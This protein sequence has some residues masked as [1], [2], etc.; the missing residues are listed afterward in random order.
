MLKLLGVIFCILMGMGFKSTCVLSHSVVSYSL[1]PHGLQPSRL[2]CPWDCPGNNT[3][4]GC[5][6]LLQG[7]FLTKESNPCLIQVSCIVGRFFTI[8]QS[9]EYV[10]AYFFSNLTNL[11]VSPS[12]KTLLGS[13]LH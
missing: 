1:Q 13:S 12:S 10:K 3:G 5:H 6:F 4:V 9:L 2:L 11:F 8:F 7:I